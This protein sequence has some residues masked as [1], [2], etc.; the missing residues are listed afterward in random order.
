LDQRINLALVGFGKFG[1]K[2]FKNIEDNKN[3]SLRTI[4][5]KNIKKKIF[6][7]FNLKNLNLYKYDA[8]IVCTPV[9]SHYKVAKLFINNKIPIIL[10]K[11]AAN[12]SNEIKKLIELSNK[13]KTSVIVNHSDLY[14]KNFQFLY[15]KRKD[16]GKIEFIE[17]HFG[18]YS[19]SY[20]DKSFL[21]HKDWLPHPLALIFQFVKEIHSI[22]IKI[23]KI[24]KKK[25]AFFQML[26]I[27]FKGSNKIK[28]KI[29]FSNIKKKVRKLT[30]YGKKGQLNYDG[31]NKKNNFI[32]SNKK[33][34]VKVENIT[35]MKNILQKLQIVSKKNI[36][37]SDLNLS[38]KIQ[39]ILNKI[40]VI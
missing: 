21:P 23:N 31:Y 30:I 15:K 17:A 13:K 24:Y 27:N 37:Y 2:Y 18:K 22:D 12:T 1:K 16:I 35:P 40:K 8:G 5:R 20:Q 14:N 36:F 10:E 32:I 38:L 39:K 19:K 29:F 26:E 7:P 4:F 9:Q 3:F 11:P 28:G 33:I 25:K 6:K 34:F